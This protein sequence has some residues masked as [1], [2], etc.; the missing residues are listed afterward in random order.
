MSV[1][2]KRFALIL[3][4]FG[5]AGD[6]VKGGVLRRRSGPLTRCPACRINR[7]QGEALSRCSICGGEISGAAIAECAMRPGLVVMATPSSQ[8]FPCFAQRAEPLDIQ[9]FVRAPVH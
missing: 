5:Q 9:A 3:E 7:D 8:T 1:F 2:E 6:R 4:I